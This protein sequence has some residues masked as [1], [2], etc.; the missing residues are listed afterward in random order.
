MG[1]NQREQVRILAQLSV[2]MVAF[3]ESHD[4]KLNRNSKLTNLTDMRKHIPRTSI[5]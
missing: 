2:A 5:Y 3:A 1:T 4:L